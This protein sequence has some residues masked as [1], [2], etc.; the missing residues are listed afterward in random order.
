MKRI[1][2]TV[3]EEYFL[4]DDWEIVKHPREQIECLLG[5]NTYFLPD[6]QWADR[7]LHVE[8]GKFEA[9]PRSTW[10]DVNEDRQ[11]WFIARMQTSDAQFCEIK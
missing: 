3:T 7:S 11:N 10:G 1:R 9:E 2:V 6:L 8:A 5:E 4:P